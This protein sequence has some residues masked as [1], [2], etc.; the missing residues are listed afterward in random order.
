MLLKICKQSYEFFSLS[1]K[2]QSGLCILLKSLR[3][4][5]LRNAHHHFGKQY[6]ANK[7]STR[8][9]KFHNKPFSIAFQ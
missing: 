6:K 4:E 2:P 1:I 5:N 7:D 9:F 3:T 8:L